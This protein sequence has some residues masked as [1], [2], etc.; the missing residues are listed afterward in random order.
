MKMVKEIFIFVRDI[1]KDTFTSIVDFFTG[2]FYDEK[3]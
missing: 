1:F 2:V 3:D